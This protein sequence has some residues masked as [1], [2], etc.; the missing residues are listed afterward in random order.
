MA[1]LS[2]DSNAIETLDDKDPQRMACAARR[3][4][5]RMR[6]FLDK[7]IPRLTKAA[8]KGPVSEHPTFTPAKPPP[9]KPRR[10]KS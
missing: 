6:T 5:V 9:T 10:N 3:E 7:E 8:P 1:N 4:K 2:A